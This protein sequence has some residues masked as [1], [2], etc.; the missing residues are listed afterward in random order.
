MF[1]Y[2]T[3]S[4]PLLEPSPAYEVT[5]QAWDRLNHR[6]ESSLPLQ[7]SSSCRCGDR[8]MQHTMGDPAKKKK[9]GARRIDMEIYVGFYVV[10]A[11]PLF[12]SLFALAAATA[13]HRELR[14]RHLW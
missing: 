4:S 3:R 8:H 9:T 2:P 5:E 11:E 10:S 13:L 14:P 7:K 6:D 12:F 1:S